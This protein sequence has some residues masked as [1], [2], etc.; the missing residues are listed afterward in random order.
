MLGVVQTEGRGTGDRLMGEVS[1][2]LLAE[3]LPVAGVFQ[4]N[5]EFDPARPCHMDL[6]LLDGSA[7]FRISENRGPLSRG[8]RLDPGALEA[9]AGRVEAALARA[10]RLLVVNKFGKQE[11]EG[12]GFRPAIGWALAA[13]VAVLTSVRAGNRAAF[14]AF[15]GDLAEDLPPDP[16]AIHAWARARCR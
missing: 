5:I 6:S 8:C 10:P 12:R 9:A 16:A 4:E 11:A 7:R 15:A 14:D 2:V 13:G 1:R 3:G